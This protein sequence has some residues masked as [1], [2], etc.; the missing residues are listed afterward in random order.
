MVHEFIA[1]LVQV[2]HSLAPTNSADAFRLQMGLCFAVCFLA[3]SGYC[4]KCWMPP[5]PKP[6][7]YGFLLAGVSICFGMAISICV[8]AIWEDMKYTVP[9]AIIAALLMPTG[10]DR[11]IEKGNKAVERKISKI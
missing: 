2:K 10:V 9:S 3:G 1:M 7:S 11:W 5:N 8:Y 6:I 4:L